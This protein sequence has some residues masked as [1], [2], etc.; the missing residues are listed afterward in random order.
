MA[1]KMACPTQIGSAANRRDRVVQFPPI[2]HSFHRILLAVIISIL[3]TQ[4]SRAQG[5]DAPCQ[6][7]TTGGIR[8][9][10][11]RFLTAGTSSDA[12]AKVEPFLQ[13]AVGVYLRDD[14]RATVFA[15]NPALSSE[16]EKALKPL[17]DAV[18][19]L[20]P[21]GDAAAQRVRFLLGSELQARGC[22]YVIGGEV[23]AGTLYII[24]PYL[25]DV[26][27]A[28]LEVPFEPV[29]GED[30]TRNARDLATRFSQILRARDSPK[31]GIKTELVV[32]CFGL[33]NTTDRDQADTIAST[34]TR[35]VSG[36]ISGDPNY[37]AVRPLGS[38]CSKNSTAQPDEQTRTIAF[39][40]DIESASKRVILL[41]RFVVKEPHRS[42]AVVTM[43]R[44]REQESREELIRQYTNEVRT[45]IVAFGRPVV[46][47]SA[48]EPL[49]RSRRVTDADVGALA[50]E[51][52]AMLREARYTEAFALAYR[53]ISDNPDSSK[54]ISLS[55]FTI[56]QALLKRSEPALA[57]SQLTKALAMQDG[58]PPLTKAQLNE[59]LGMT[60][61]TLGAFP[62]AITRLEDA[63][64]AYVGLGLDKQ[65][66][67]VRKEIA[68]VRIKMGDLKR[69]KTDL[70]SVSGLSS[71]FDALLL[72]SQ[73]SFKAGDLDG[74][75]GALQWANDALKVRPDAPE[76]RS[77]AEDIYGA[78]GQRA[79]LDKK[80]KVAES[81][82][83]TS[84]S[85]E[86]KPQYRYLAGFSAYTDSGFD[87]AIDD[88]RRITNSTAPTPYRW[89]EAA[90]LTLL[91]C[92][93]LVGNYA[94]AD[95]QGE[96]AMQTAFLKV[97]DSQLVAL[98]LRTVARALSD[99]VQEASIFEK[100]AVY[101]QTLAGVPTQ[102]LRL[103]WDNKRLA[104]YYEKVLRD[105][106]EKLRKIRDLAQQLFPAPTKG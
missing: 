53:V 2:T 29:V 76:A 31:E 90:W 12:A 61:T 55:R 30:L 51:F 40:G 22:D 54:D 88:F 10:V 32:G 104:T 70:L 62:N 98:Y 52:D 78:I 69:A 28:T 4:V 8:I 95:R 91:E 60:Y 100:D 18:F 67:T 9:L 11:G 85:L 84:L 6:G 39:G 7:A 15:S 50:A 59:T 93:I 106:P 94:E 47:W 45:F 16:S 80:P 102:K 3:G 87:R 27:A 19:S 83:R 79:L 24:T 96:R 14:P 43:E 25:F 5:M 81:A 38:A 23:N 82:F 57:L 63:S 103:N 74:P 17:I 35:M 44:I 77:A 49:W 99:P 36:E 21:Q 42:P 58:L 37:P 105:N 92:Y 97:P 65:G 46:E 26:R 34:I 64:T 41:P 66:A 101:Q 89:T 72:L 75:Q 56:G 33:P 73:V 71:D 48:L 86:E 20:G 1:L 13:A 68:A